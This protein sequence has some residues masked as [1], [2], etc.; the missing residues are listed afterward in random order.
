MFGMDTAG[1]RAY[2]CVVLC[3]LVVPKPGGVGAPAPLAQTVAVRRGPGSESDIM[4]IKRD[5]F[6]IASLI[7]LAIPS[8]IRD[9]AHRGPVQ[10]IVL[11]C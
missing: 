10:L 1:R 7:P 9:R 2:P 11:S 6:T 5:N 3:F 4:G 8:P